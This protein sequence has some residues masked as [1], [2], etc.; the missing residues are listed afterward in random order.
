MVEP[1][2]VMVAEADPGVRNLTSRVLRRW[3]LYEVMEADDGEQALGLI[4]PELEVAVVEWALP[5]ADGATLCR[6]LK[7]GVELGRRYVIVV[8]GTDDNEQIMQ[9]LEAGA[10]DY[11][12]KPVDPDDLLER[13]VAGQ[14]ALRSARLGQEGDRP[15]AMPPHR[16][17][18]T[19][20]FTRD[21]FDGRL[22]EEL[23]RARSNR[24]PLALTLVD[25]DAF[26]RVN[27][28]HRRQVGDEMLGEIGRM[29]GEQT[30]RTTDVPARYGDDEFAVIAPNT[31]MEGARGL[32]ERLR[33]LALHVRVRAQDE[34]VAV[35]A[36]VGFAIFGRRLWRE[37]DPGPALVEAAEHRLYQ[38]RLRG[39]NCVAG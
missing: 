38:A 17:P 7:S 22:E 36:S 19:G 33:R 37:S 35:T 30:R 18:L 25:L 3:G 21:Y 8:F 28:I 4:R 5:G 23:E 32:A 26:R 31:N 2:T 12:L 9:A 13:V 39:G 6:R 34:L 16:D 20:L 24:H 11:A 14:S 29:I 15:A 1:T 27:E 10:D